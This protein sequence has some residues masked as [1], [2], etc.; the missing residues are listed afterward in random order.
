MSDH[1]WVPVWIG[2][3]A[4]LGDS[5]Q[6]ISH[7]LKTLAGR[8]DM[9]CSAVSSLYRSAPIGGVDQP[10]FFNALARFETILEPFSLLDILLDLETTLGRVRGEIRFGPRVIDLDL[11]LYGGR[12]IESERL[13]VPH[14]RMHLRR[15]VLEPLAEIEG[16]MVF[17]DG[18]R[19][20]SW[21]DDCL[22]QQ[23]SR[24]KRLSSPLDGNADPGV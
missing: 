18:S 6:A 16:E 17:P 14:P 1:P 4:N 13:S 8:T 15:F 3:G 20:S 5:E 23:V 10:D 2:F 24:D 9:R 12:T 7:A 19:L 22:D 21:L 11:L